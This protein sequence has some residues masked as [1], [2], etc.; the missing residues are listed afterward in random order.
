ML[1]EEVYFCNCLWKM[2]LFSVAAKK[3]I[4]AKSLDEK[5]YLVYN[6]KLK[7]WVY[8]PTYCQIITFP[9]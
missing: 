5:L 9:P 2:A 6:E 3:L 7:L 8:K 1:L 4:Q